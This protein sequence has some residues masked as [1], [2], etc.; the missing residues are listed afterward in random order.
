LTDAEVLTSLQVLRS[1]YHLLSHALDLTVDLPATCYNKRTQWVLPNRNVC[2]TQKRME[3]LHRP[4]LLLYA[5]DE[6]TFRT[7]PD[8]AET[9]RLSWKALEAVRLSTAAI[10]PDN[11]K[12]FY[13]A[14]GY[15]ICEDITKAIDQAD[16]DAPRVA[17]V[18]DVYN[19]SWHIATKHMF[20]YWPEVCGDILDGVTARFV[21]WDFDFVF[22]FVWANSEIVKKASRNRAAMFLAGGKQL[23][24]AH[25]FDAAKHFDVLCARNDYLAEKARQMF[26]DKRVYVLTNGVDTNHFK[27]CPLP[28]DEFTIGWVGRPEILLKRFELAEKVAKQVDCKLKVASY[29]HRIPH[30]LMPGFYNSIDV[31]LVTSE[32]EAHPLPVYEALSCGVPVVTTDVGDVREVITS[33]ENGYIVPVD[34]PVET[35]AEYINEL[36]DDNVREDFGKRARKRILQDWSWQTKI[37]DYKE[38]LRCE[39]E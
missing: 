22:I 25:L 2:Y 19:W 33:G 13:K 7:F 28:R 21:N 11:M 9:R 8:I 34:S 15:D 3:P 10:V 17:C 30:E 23:E 4:G 39:L 14:L 32:T 6:N 5:F 37:N 1:Y 36:K 24:N 38:F 26:P 31:L 18:I 20:R 16:R 12:D 35:F 29:E 27:P